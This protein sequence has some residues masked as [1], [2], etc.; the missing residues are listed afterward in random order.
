MLK[1]NYT[2]Q[3]IIFKIMDLSFYPWLRKRT[4]KK[5]TIPLFGILISLIVEAMGSDLVNMGPPTIDISIASLSTPLI[6]F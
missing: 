2:T 6:A 3:N 4:T 5:I 1:K